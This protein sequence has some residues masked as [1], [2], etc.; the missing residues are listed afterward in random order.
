M[1]P[2][3]TSSDLDTLLDLSGTIDGTRATFLIGLAES[4]CASIVDPVPANANVV[5]LSVAGRAYTNPDG[6]AAHTIGPESVQYGSTL[7]GLYLTKADVATLKRMAGVGGAFTVDPTPA[8]AGTLVYPW[9]ENLWGFEG[10]DTFTNPD[11]DGGADIFD[12]G[13]SVEG[14]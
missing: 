8:D 4:L 6:V 5:V 3:P 11:A 10:V 7:G 2:A 13:D 1:V 14:P 12:F 9:D